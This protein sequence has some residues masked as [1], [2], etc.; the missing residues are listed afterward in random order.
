MNRN[1][2]ILVIEDDPAIRRFLKTGLEAQGYRFEQ[3]GSGDT[4][5]ALIFS[6]QPDVV[7]LDLGLPDME[8]SQVIQEVRVK[9]DVP[10]LVLSARDQEKEKIQALELGA[11]DYITKPFGIGELLARI[12]VSLRHRLDSEQVLPQVAFGNLKLDISAR[13]VFLDQEEVHLT[14]LEYKLL[15]ILTQH[16]GKIL[17]H[18]FLLEKVWGNLS[19]EQSH[20]VRIYMASL[21]K[22]LEKD[23]TAPRFIFT[24][25]GVGYRFFE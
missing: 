7:L 14:P 13:R 19:N 15:L 4:G 20:Y 24:E 18:S 11:D 17:T 9:T 1:P 21:R 6:L 25:T 22:K 16:P 12:K 3:A 10:I 5:I 23:P 8:G 2:L